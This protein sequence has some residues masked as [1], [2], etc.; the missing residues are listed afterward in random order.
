MSVRR[1]SFAVAAAAAVVASLGVG[2]GGAAAS[3]EP[4]LAT[5]RVTL[6]NLTHGQPFSPP[7]VATHRKAV[8]MF[9]VGQ[10]A[11]DEL[12]AIAQDGNEVPMFALFNASKHTTE[13]VDVGKP[14]TPKG[15]TVGS[16]TDTV[17]IEIHARP[18]DRLSL[19]TML[20]CTNDGFLGLDAAKLPKHGTKTHLVNGYD[21]GRENNTEASQDIVDAC[22]ALNPTK[23]LAGDPNGNRNAEVATVPP[24]VIQHHPGIHG[25]A[26]LDPSFHGWTNPVASITIERLT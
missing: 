9:E 11:S 21:A 23:P 20:I 1:R 17:T 2:L 22:S 13:A 10:L 12:A 16:F 26:Q 18:G 6:M 14:V 8:H 3:A 7:V 24:T 25:G 19:A 15:T 5:Y 4:E